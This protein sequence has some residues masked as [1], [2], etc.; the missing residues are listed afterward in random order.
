MAINLCSWAQGNGHETTTDHISLDVAQL[1][2]GGSAMNVSVKLDATS[3][4]TAVG[5]DIVLPA[6]YTWGLNRKG[7]PSITLDTS[8]D[9]ELLDNTFTYGANIQS[10]GSLRVT[11]YS[12]SSEDFCDTE[13]LIFKFSLVATPYAKPGYA[14]IQIKNCYFTTSAGIQ[15]DTKDITISDKVSASNNSTVPV[16]VSAEAKWGTCILPFSCALPSGVKAYTCN[17]KDENN[18]LLTE[19]PQLAAYT[20]Y[21]LYSEEGYS[22]NFSGTV[23]A[24][25]YPAE[26][27]V[28]SGY[29]S[30]AIVPQVVNNGY[31]L[32]NLSEGVKFYSCGD[33]DFNIPAGKC[34]VNI[35]GG[36][37]RER[38]G[39]KIENSLTGISN[40]AESSDANAIYNLSGLRVKDAAAPGIYVVNKKKV[41]KK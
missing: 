7:N 17:S 1:T 26:G 30:G 14:D 9:S 5:M 15:Y 41:L 24:N 13:G 31:V 34:W 8:E 19:D 40:V 35:D 33:E 20:P 3:F 18:L 29:L 36:S 22:G 38:L 32:Q 4:Y 6:G 11:V 2:P 25:E 37:A 10:D 23:D 12:S 39:F 16:S 21:I 28:K 27:F